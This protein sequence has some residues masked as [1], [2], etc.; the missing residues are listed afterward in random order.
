MEVSRKG[1]SSQVLW[2]YGVARMGEICGEEDREA[3]YEDGGLEKC[4]GVCAV[5]ASMSAEM[6]LDSRA[7][8]K[9][10]SLPQRPPNP[11]RR[12]GQGVE[13]GP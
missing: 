6:I 13:P 11:L 5:A 8:G 1:G 3:W 7:D 4:P 12:H 10:P 2:T 9:V